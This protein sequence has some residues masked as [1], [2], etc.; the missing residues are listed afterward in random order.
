M[1]RSRPFIFAA[2]LAA[3]LIAEGAAWTADVN[4]NGIDAA[5]EGECVD[6]TRTGGRCE[7]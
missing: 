1:A 6:I 3:T 7:C 2:V 5:A 4:C